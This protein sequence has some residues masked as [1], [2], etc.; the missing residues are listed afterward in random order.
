MNKVLMLALALLLLAVGGESL[1][2]ADTCAPCPAEKD[3]NCKGGTVPDLCDCCVQCA[4]VIGEECGGPYRMMGYCDLGLYC[5]ID[6]P[7][8]P[9]ASGKYAEMVIPPGE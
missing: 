8:D 7:N 3:L 1:S 6:D 4:K 9:N 2:C 5:H